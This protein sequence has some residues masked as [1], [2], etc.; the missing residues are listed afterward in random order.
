MRAICSIISERKV[1]INSGAEDLSSLLSKG[2]LKFCVTLGAFNLELYFGAWALPGSLDLMCQLPGKTLETGPKPHLRA[3]QLITSWQKLT[4]LWK[5]RKISDLE[6]SLC[7]WFIITLNCMFKTTFFF[8]TLIPI[9]WN[10]DV[11]IYLSLSLYKLETPI[12]L[13][14]FPK[15]LDILGSFLHF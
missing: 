10:A 7:L 5:W 6:K 8:L 1:L 12:P 3:V 13:Y 2:A 9:C 4:Y 14:S 11:C 15:K